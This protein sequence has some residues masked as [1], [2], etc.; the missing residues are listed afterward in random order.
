MKMNMTNSLIRCD[1]VILPNRYTRPSICFVDRESCL[2]N[3]DHERGGLLVIQ[4]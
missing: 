3:T 4:V 2:T 1:P